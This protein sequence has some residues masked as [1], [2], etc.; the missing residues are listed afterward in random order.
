MSKKTVNEK[1][2]EVF[3]TTFDTNEEKEE[4]K[5]LQ[6]YSGSLHNEVDKEKDYFLVRKNMKELINTGEDAIEGILKVATEG[7]S[8]RAY[9][10]AAQMIKTVAEMNQDLIDLHKKM[11][12]IK[13]EETTINNR[14]QNTL[15]VGSTR[16]LQDLINESRS[17]KKALGD[18]IIDVEEIND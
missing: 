16:D 4:K 10:V 6:K 3:D 11:K 1:I 13:K 8:P 17:A 2:S 18:N 12:D 14:T 5:S 9:E 15:Y 7:D